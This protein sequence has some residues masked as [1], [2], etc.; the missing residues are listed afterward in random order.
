MVTPLSRFP[1]TTPFTFKGTGGREPAQRIVA[2]PYAEKRPAGTYRGCSSHV[3]YH[4]ML[5]KETGLDTVLVATTD[6]LHAAASMAAMRKRKHVF[7]SA[8]FM[9]GANE[10][11]PFG[12]ETSRS[13]QWTRKG[14]R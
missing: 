6:N 5:E 12:V 1:V 11:G 10:Q 14:W 7:G 2:D 4:E 3:D 9:A 8:D 13:S